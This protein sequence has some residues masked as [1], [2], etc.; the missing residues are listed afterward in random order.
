MQN[1]TNCGIDARTFPEIWKSLSQ[2]EQSDLRYT[3]MLKMKV[4]RQTIENWSKK[5][6]MPI[7]QGAKEE[8]SRIVSSKLGIKT[9]WQT[10]FPR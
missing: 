9:S 2:N 5:G 1:N 4:T 10:L 7:Y 6:V 8:V 3:L